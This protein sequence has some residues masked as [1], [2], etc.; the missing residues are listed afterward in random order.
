LTACQWVIDMRSCNGFVGMSMDYVLGWKFVF[1]FAVT[2]RKRKWKTVIGSFCGKDVKESVM[3]VVQGGRSVR[4]AALEK[5]EIDDNTSH[6]TAKPCLA[7]NLQHRTRNFSVC[8]LL[9]YSDMNYPLT[10]VV[11]HGLVT[12]Y[13]MQGLE[14]KCR[15]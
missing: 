5:E 10:T 1:C 14:R 2:V 4:Q 15:A 12:L 13:Q 7:S 3:L 8:Y 11:C 9:Q 6:D